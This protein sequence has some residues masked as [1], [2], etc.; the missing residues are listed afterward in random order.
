MTHDTPEMDC[1]V[2]P[3]C[4]TRFGGESGRL[5]SVAIVEALAAAEHADPTQLAP[6]A[7]EV[8][9]EPLE[10]LVTG[11]DSV[12][13]RLSLRGWPVLVRGDGVLR[14]YDPDSVADADFGFEREAEC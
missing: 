4:D 2:T 12:R 9:L 13:V 1:T 7:D 10:A 11:S 14:V 5:V 6:L 3:V 8:D